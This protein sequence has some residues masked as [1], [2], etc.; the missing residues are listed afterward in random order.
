MRGTSHQHVTVFWRISFSSPRVL[1]TT[2]LLVETF[3]F[4]P[5]CC[6]IQVGGGGRRVIPYLLMTK[7]TGII[8]YKSFVG[9]S[10]SIDETNIKWKGLKE[11][12]FFFSLILTPFTLKIV[13][14][15]L[16]SLCASSKTCYILYPQLKKDFNS[17]YS[18]FVPGSWI[19][20]SVLIIV[21][22]LL[23][24]KIMHIINAHNVRV[25]VPSLR[26]GIKLFWNRWG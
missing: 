14:V 16:H 6:F 8:C 17:P 26:Q 10:T 5:Q 23:C 15:Q 9:L 20:P 24:S 21:I 19:L 25:L 18:S 3:G 13:A 12:L 7:E 4:P 1:I 22:L 11:T 2:V